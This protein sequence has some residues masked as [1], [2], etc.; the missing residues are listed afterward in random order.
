MLR[1]IFI[2]L[3]DK[4]SYLN[5]FQYVTF[6]VA[7][8]AITAFLLSVIIMP[9]VIKLQLKKQVGEVIRE[10]GPET[11]KAKQGTPTMGG[12]YYLFCYRCFCTFMDGY[13]TH[14]H[15]DSVITFILDLDSWGL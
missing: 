7:Y 6:R 4:F 8:G 9:F 15:M 1:E 11:H 2:P 3:I 10:E 12:N 13:K 5:L 14:I